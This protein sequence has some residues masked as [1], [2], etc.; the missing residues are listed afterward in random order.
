MKDRPVDQTA[1]IL[2][3][4]GNARKDSWSKKLLSVAVTGAIDAGVPV[5]VIDLRDLPMPIYDGDLEAA[6]D[7]PT[8]AVELRRL[9]TVHA[10]F[11]IATPE[12][13]GSVSAL[14]KNALDWCSRPSGGQDGLAPFRGKPVALLSASLSPF[15]G[16][17]G[18]GH[19]RAIMAKMGATV[20]GDEVLLPTAHKAFTEG[21]SLIEAG[22]TKLTQALGA[23]LAGLVRQ[24]APG[25]QNQVRA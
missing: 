20:I 19:L 23:S 18:I 11:L 4:A 14:L 12:H 6:S 13:N 10:G 22:V 8:A 9:M 24:I 2:A 17:R 7:L 25:T 3:F 15:G 21:N 1:E 5:T 16:V